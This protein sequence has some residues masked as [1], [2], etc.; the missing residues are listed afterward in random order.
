MFLLQVSVLHG[1]RTKTTTK[2]IIKKK[3]H[4]LWLEGL[5][6]KCNGAR[7]IFVN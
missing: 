7:M 3:T 5:T 1:S 6:V 4:S 2:I